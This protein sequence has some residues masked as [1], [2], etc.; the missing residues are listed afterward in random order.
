METIKVEDEKE[1]VKDSKECFICGKEFMHAKN[2]ILHERIHSNETPYQCNYCM[3]QFKGK[4]DLT[5]HERIHKGE[6][7]YEC[8]TCH[9]TF[10]VAGYLRKH[11]KFMKI[12]RSLNVTLVIKHFVK[13]LTWKF[14]R[15]FIVDVMLQ[16]LPRTCW[17]FQLFLV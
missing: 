14:T 15:L 16:I 13:R 17:R 4:G 9:K 12:K 2:L 1:K 7:P 6:K 10:R 8:K 3:R 11:K 5:K